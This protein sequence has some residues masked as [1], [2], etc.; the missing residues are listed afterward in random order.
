MRRPRA[1]ST[2]SV[3][4][5]RARSRLLRRDRISPERAGG[6]PRPRTP[7]YRRL[8]ARDRSRRGSDRADGERLRRIRQGIRRPAALRPRLRGESAT[9]QHARTR[10]GR[11][12]RGRA[13]RRAGRV[14]ATPHRGAL[15]VHAAARA[16]PRRRGRAHPDAARLRSD[17]CRRRP[18][19][20]RLGRHV[21]ADAA[22]PR[23]ET[24]R[25]P[26]RRA[27]GRAA[28]PDCHGQRRLP[29]SPERR[30]PHARAP[31]DRL[32]DNHLVN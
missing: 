32:V 3:S 2:G 15:P 7:Q 20:L 6:R 13:A 18:S 21:F 14:D 29:D 1:C 28:G 8:V 5:W 12:D 17:E 26:A 30:G 10:S 27:R 4:A 22:R 24:A 11:G 31:L 19:V 25:Q 9:R 16:A 23:D